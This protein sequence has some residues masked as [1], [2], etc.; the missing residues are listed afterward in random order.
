MSIHTEIQGEILLVRLSRPQKRNA[1][2]DATIL[3]IETIFSNIPE[4][5]KCAIIYGET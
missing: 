3:N 1:L 5:I 4:G 2:N